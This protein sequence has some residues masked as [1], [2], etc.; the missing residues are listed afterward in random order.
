MSTRTQSRTG[1][2][3]TDLLR[4]RIIESG[5]PYIELERRTGVIRQVLM[6]FSKGEQRGIRLEAVEKLMAYFGLEVV[7]V[8]KRPT[9]KRR[10]SAKQPAK[11]S[12]KGKA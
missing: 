5:L 7:E 8:T 6:A 12:K 11:R 9:P 10:A 1:L 2:S 3:L 4:Q